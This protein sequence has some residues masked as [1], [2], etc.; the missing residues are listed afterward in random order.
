MDPISAIP[1]IFKAPDLIKSTA[2]MLGLVESVD[3][4]ID[5]MLKKDFNNGIRLLNELRLADKRHE[6]IL[7]QAYTSFQGAI[8]NER[9]KRKAIA[10]IGLAFCQYQLGEKKIAASTL[11]EFANWEYIDTGKRVVQGASALVGPTI[12]VL[13]PIVGLLVISKDIIW[14]SNDY[15]KLFKHF[16]EIPSEKAVKELQESA[17][18]FLEEEQVQIS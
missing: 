11:Q 7:E 8:N 1:L 2:A 10:Y 18:K 14:K 3:S 12:P 6:F 16:S 17:L 13:F 5:K 15:D 4:K 9:G